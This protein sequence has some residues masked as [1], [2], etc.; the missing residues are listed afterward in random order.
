MR[1]AAGPGDNH[2][3][4]RFRPK[5]RTQ[6][7]DR[8]FGAPIRRMF[9]WNTEVLESLRR[10]APA[11]PNPKTNHDDADQW[12]LAEIESFAILAFTE[13]ADILRCFS[14]RRDLRRCFQ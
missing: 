9:M 3:D 2:L 14:A 4:A 10:R 11:F 5:Q 7:G 6:K 12:K 8:A 13:E 1:G